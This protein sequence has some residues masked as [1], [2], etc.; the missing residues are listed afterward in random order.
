MKIS[1][2]EFLN[3]IKAQKE[4]EVKVANELG[5]TIENAKNEVVKLLLD[6]IRMDSIKHAHILQSLED[7]IKGKIFSYVEKTE[8]KN[9]LEKHIIKEQEMLSKIE[10]ITKKVEENHVKL[11]LDGILNEEQRHH[12]SLKQLYE[13]LERI[14]GLTEEDL[15]D[16][17][18]RWA[19]FST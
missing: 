1:D 11:I 17:L 3:L 12:A 16:Y 19:N 9:A 8:L 14:E 2:E 6:V 4:L 7:I 15:W 5:L 18:N 13:F 10:E